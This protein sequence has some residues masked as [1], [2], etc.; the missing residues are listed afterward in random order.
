MRGLFSWG[1][2]PEALGDYVTGS[3]PRI[4]NLGRSAFFIRS[5]A[6][7]FRMKRMSVRSA[8]PSGFRHLAG[9]AMALAEAEHLPAHKRSVSIRFEKGTDV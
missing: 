6:F 4:A 8:T 2:G 3:E 1:M 7:R 9:A 5:W